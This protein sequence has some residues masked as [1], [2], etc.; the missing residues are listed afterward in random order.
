[1]PAD[2]TMSIRNSQIRCVELGAPHGVACG[3]SPRPRHA[4]QRRLVLR[5]HQSHAYP[6]RGDTVRVGGDSR[7]APVGVL[8]R[9]AAG[10]DFVPY[11]AY[12]GGGIRHRRPQWRGSAR[13]Q[14]DGICWQSVSLH[15]NSGHWI[16]PAQR[17]PRSPL[18][19]LARAQE[20]RPDV[21]GAPTPR[22]YGRH[23]VVLLANLNRRRPYDRLLVSSAATRICPSGERSLPKSQVPV[24]RQPFLVILIASLRLHG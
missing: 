18:I 9:C 4:G 24:W 15:Q 6:W 8:A 3:L 23:L 21:Y 13:D 11:H 5:D 1:M 2:T 19:R 17:V 14:S 10:G 20:P 7:L 22:R 12:G 16:G